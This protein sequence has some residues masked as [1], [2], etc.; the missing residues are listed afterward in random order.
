MQQQASIIEA[1]AALFRADES[2]KQGHHIMAFTVVTIF[3]LPLGFFAGFVGMNNADTR[4]NPWMTLRE[5][6]AYMSE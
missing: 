3:F 5:Q 4:N 6:V 1:K 2:I